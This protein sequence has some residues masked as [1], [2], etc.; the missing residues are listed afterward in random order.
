MSVPCVL[1]WAEWATVTY[2]RVGKLKTRVGK[3]KKF[4][5]RFVSNFIKQMYAHPGLKPCRHPSGFTDY[6]YLGRFVRWTIRTMDFSYH[7][8]FVLWT[9]RTICKIFSQHLLLAR[10][11]FSSPGAHPTGCLSNASRPRRKTSHL[12]VQ[13]WRFGYFLVIIAKPTSSCCLLVHIF[14]RHP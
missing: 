5:R 10:R 4:F 6:S 12:Y 8:L 3:R 9:V 1:Q 11:S 14:C 2:G 13:L 7:G